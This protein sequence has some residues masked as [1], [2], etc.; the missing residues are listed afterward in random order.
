M[1]NPIK[2]AAGWLERM[3]D[4]PA[5]F[6]RNLGKWW[7]QYAALLL[8]GLALR[9][10]TF[11]DP[12]LHVD[13]SF[14]FLVG[15]E[16]H[17]G[18]LPYVDIW[19]RKPLGLF[20]I[21]YLIAGI[22]TSVVA[23]QVVA[24]LFASSTAMVINLIARRWV[25]V[26]GA[27]LA[28]ASYLF[29]L[30]P[31][32]GYG[33]QSPVFYNL[34]MAGAAALLLIDRSALHRG[35]PSWRTF[36][37]MGLCGLALTVK[38]TALFESLF[39]GLFTSHVVLRSGASWNRKLATIAA[40]ATVGA[41][42]TI[43]V[44]SAYLWLG[45]WP[46]WWQ[47][48]VLS[49]LAKAKRHIF[50]TTLDLLRMILHLYPFICLAGIGL[51]YAKGRWM[52]SADHRF[53]VLWLVFAALGVI[54][55]P[56]FYTHY[57]LPLLVPLAI[58]SSLIQVHRVVGVFAFTAVALFTVVLYNPVNLERRAKS[59]SAMH[60]MA[61]MI[62]LNDNA[63]GVLVY[64]GP[65]YLYALSGKRPLTP[66]SFPHHMH[67]AMERNVSTI[68]TFDE[69]TRLLRLRPGAVVV[70]VFP[71]IEP[72]NAETRFLVTSYVYNNCRLLAAVTSRDVS[73]V[74]LIGVWGDCRE[75]APDLTIEHEPV[76]EM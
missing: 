44:G 50:S 54:S 41:L 65:P 61:K 47:A 69:V 20:I 60:E 7:Q 37:A 10:A 52:N 40:C 16:M 6:E 64:D 48:M 8:L 72:K 32:E 12:N 76:D 22:S 39:F 25:G 15:Q 28:G 57:A 33:G 13:E 19:D 23:Y 63:R 67:H 55:V 24:W 74:Q 62:Q 68:D 43:A 30:G 58:G 1:I 2:V 70:A 73:T 34:F 59:I 49:N 4:T 9:V 42:P 14:Y 18:A 31:Q 56:N 46:E 53:L 66:L 45:H 29:M 17:K 27:V 3:P 5:W 75:G 38:Q 26:Q 21:Y 35:R 11:G 71:S 51:G 36:T